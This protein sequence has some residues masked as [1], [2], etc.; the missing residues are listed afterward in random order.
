[1]VPLAIAKELGCKLVKDKNNYCYITD[2]VHYMP[3]HMAVAMKKV[4]VYANDTNVSD[5]R[6][7][8]IKS[9]TPNMILELPLNIRVI[10]WLTSDSIKNM[11]RSIESKFKE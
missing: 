7:T 3:Y 10:N 8:I 11:V 5:E 1:M 4:W 9:K 6:I 2:D